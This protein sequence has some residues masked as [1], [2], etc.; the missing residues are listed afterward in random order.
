MRT[1]LFFLLFLCGLRCAFCAGGP[2]HTYRKTLDQPTEIQGY[3]CARGYAWFFDDGRLNR[4]TVT[5]EILFGEARIPAGSYIALN[6]EGTPNLVQMS[7]DA[8]ILGMTC[9]G[10]SWLG[11]SEGSVVAFYPSG[12]LKL[13]Y[14]AQDQTV[15]GVPC[16]PSSFWASLTGVNPGV[17]FDESGKLRACKLTK[18]Y[19][20]Q[21]KGER[22]VRAR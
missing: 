5:R 2:P 16:A 19:G 10:G 14:L 18:D 13:C 20:G 8:P 3:P 17:L 7:H 21:H 11:P 22:F 12:K 9:M 6:P 15:Q 4:C 1:A